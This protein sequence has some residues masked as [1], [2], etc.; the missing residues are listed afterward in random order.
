MRQPVICFADPFHH[1]SHM[2]GA[3]LQLILLARAFVCTGFTV[4]YVSDDITTPSVEDGVQM[5]PFSSR[6]DPRAAQASFV[7]TM[8]RIGAN[9]L[10]QRGRKGYTAFLP[11]VE[12]ETSCRTIFATSMDID[13]RQLKETPRLTRDFYRDP[14]ILFRIPG[15]I[16]MDRETLNG[17]RAASLVLAQ[18]RHQQEMLKRRLGIHAELMRNVHPVNEVD[19]GDKQ[20]PPIVLWLANLKP[21]KRPEDFLH[22]VHALPDVECTFVMAGRLDG[23]SRLLH[24]IRELEA[25]DSRFK[26]LGAVSR[27]QSLELYREASIFVNTSARNE[28]VPNAFIQA[29]LAR[30]PVITRE[31]DPDG[32][33]EAHGLGLVSGRI[34]SLARDIRRCLDD[35]ALR[36]DLGTRARAFAIANFD[37]KTQFPRMLTLV[38]TLLSARKAN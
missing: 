10:Y 36:A 12:V 6:G 25:R 30:T 17:M 35:D 24:D 38:E 19:A 28:G 32:V 31:V 13:C 8:K 23:D 22:L 11:S 2:G 18:S 20:H 29:W 26:Y 21:W 14:R 5:Q 9:V 4:H 1:L 33:I 27:E 15:A 34:E 3:E 7:Q 37:V 16:R